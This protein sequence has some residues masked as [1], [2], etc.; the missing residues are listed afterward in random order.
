MVNIFKYFYRP[1]YF[2]NVNNDL[3]VRYNEVAAQELAHVDPGKQ[4]PF[5]TDFKMGTLKMPQ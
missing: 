3:I 2:T 1:P 5:I 4:D